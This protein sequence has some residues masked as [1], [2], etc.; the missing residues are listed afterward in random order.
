MRKKAI[1]G[2]RT[3]Y[4][5]SVKP[6]CSCQPIHTI[7]LHLKVPVFQILGK[8]F[9]AISA[10]RLSCTT[11][12]TLRA[13]RTIKRT[14]RTKKNYVS[15]VIRSH[16]YSE[17]F[18]FRCVECLCTSSLAFLHDNCEKGRKRERKRTKKIFFPRSLHGKTGH[19][20]LSEEKSL[21]D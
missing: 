11:D 16:K 7:T 8:Q 18:V 1:I 17:R 20:F 19:N 10:K 4:K 3:M 14:H 5:H 12:N 2:P 9:H 13:F 15:L 21:Y 6:T